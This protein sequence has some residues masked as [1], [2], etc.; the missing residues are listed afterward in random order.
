ME[1][2]KTWLAL[3][4]LAMTACADGDDSSGNGGGD[5]SDADTDADG[6]TDTDTDTDA[7]TDTDTD[8]DTDVQG[9]VADTIQVDASFGYEE[10][11]GIRTMTFDGTELGN[12]VA[13]TVL[14]YADYTGSGNPTQFCFVTWTLQE[15][16][17]VSNGDFPGEYWVSFDLS[18]ASLSYSG[19]S[20][21][22]PVGD[23]EGMETFM[24]RARGDTDLASFVATW[25]VG[26]GIESLQDLDGTTLNDWRS[27]VWPDTFAEDY[28]PW[29]Q[30]SPGLAAG[31]FTMLGSA[32]NEADVMLAYS[33]DE[34][35]AIDYDPETKTTT[36]VTMTGLSAAPT[37]YY[38]SLVMYAF[39]D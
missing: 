3:S 16:P 20:L 13:A 37:A 34:N 28:G 27:N 14:N 12:V 7:D 32:P 22:G 19:E 31:S 38:Q 23:C 35:G 39:G 36:L 26:F 33:V 4:G 10:G 9:W 17:I 1:T 25:D 6:D 24:G 29:N 11:T 2:W 15:G 30:I 21:G 8:T 5:E 18:S